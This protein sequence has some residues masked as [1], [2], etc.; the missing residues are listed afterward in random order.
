MLID[1]LNKFFMIMFFMACLTSIRHGYYFIQ[2]ILV[3]SEEEPAKYRLSKMGL[4]SLCISVAYILSVI[5][6]GITI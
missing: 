4:L 2:T 6:T 1:I 3:N 5:F